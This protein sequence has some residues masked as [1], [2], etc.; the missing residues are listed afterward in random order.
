M[1]A[2]KVVASSIF[3]TIMLPHD[4]KVVTIDQLTY[5]DPKSQLHLEN[6]LPTLE[7]SQSITSFSD[8]CP[9]ICQYYSLLGTYNGPP[10]PI[11]VL[12]LRLYL[13]VLLACVR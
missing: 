8:V 4:G 1:C 3:R 10:P 13:P 5:Y 6:V 12:P 2:M 7:G 11:M 9:E